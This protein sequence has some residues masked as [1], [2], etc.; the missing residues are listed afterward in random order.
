MLGT[1]DEDTPRSLHVWFRS[2]LIS[3]SGSDHTEMYR[4]SNWLPLSSRFRIQLFP[5][6]QELTY[7]FIF[8]HVTVQK[9]SIDISDLQVSYMYTGIN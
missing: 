1:L 6:D 5:L 4:L 8:I 7:F 2:A 3:S 9:L